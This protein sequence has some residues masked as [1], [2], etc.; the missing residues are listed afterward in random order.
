MSPTV[1][2]LLAGH[3]PQVIHEIRN[4]Q[5]AIRNRKGS[6]RCSATPAKMANTRKRRWTGWGCEP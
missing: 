4:P 6:I 3:E 1:L 2:T 5:S